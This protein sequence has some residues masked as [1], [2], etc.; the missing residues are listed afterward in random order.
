MRSR[1]PHQVEKK[2]DAG[3]QGGGLG[4]SIRGIYNPCLL[5]LISPSYVTCESLLF[6]YPFIPPGCLHSL[7]VHALLG[8]HDVR[9]ENHRSSPAHIHQRETKKEG[10][11]EDEN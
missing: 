11:G 6:P 9:H 2:T 5:L 8:Q 4:M 3:L 10:G 7:D 1:I